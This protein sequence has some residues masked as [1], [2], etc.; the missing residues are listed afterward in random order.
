[1]DPSV[2][3]GGK[4]G[5]I[6]P[7]FTVDFY[8]ISVGIDPFMQIKTVFHSSLDL[9]K[10]AFRF[11]CHRAPVCGL[12]HLRRM[13]TAFHLE[14]SLIVKNPREKNRVGLG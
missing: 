7:F 5:W 4:A 11:F 9:L 14:I 1:M 3:V 13:G 10:E 2:A 12:Y 8:D 6:G